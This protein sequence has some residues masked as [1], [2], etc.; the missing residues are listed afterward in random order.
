MK[1]SRKMSSKADWLKHAKVTS[2]SGQFEKNMFMSKF[3]A[4]QSFTRRFFVPF[5]HESPNKK[6][7]Y[8]RITPQSNAGY[9]K[10]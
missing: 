9:P 3:L 8:Y 2:Y 4:N 10:L 1:K 7:V 5:S 6:F